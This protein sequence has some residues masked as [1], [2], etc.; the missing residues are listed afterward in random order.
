MKNKCFQPVFLIYLQLLKY[1]LSVTNSYTY[2]NFPIVKLNIEFITPDVPD[3]GEVKSKGNSFDSLS[4]FV[5]SA[6]KLY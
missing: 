1:L 2:S 3:Y 4:M 6:N 5:Y